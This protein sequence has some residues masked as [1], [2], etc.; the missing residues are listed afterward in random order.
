[1]GEKKVRRWC[2]VVQGPFRVRKAAR[3]GLGRDKEVSIGEES[4]EVDRGAPGKLDSA[5]SL[6]RV[7]L[8]EMSSVQEGL[9]FERSRGEIP[10]SP[11]KVPERLGQFQLWEPSNDDEAMIAAAVEEEE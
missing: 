5:V 2:E 10:K 11:G 1:V 6:S 9:F 8:R 3:R 7:P 4:G